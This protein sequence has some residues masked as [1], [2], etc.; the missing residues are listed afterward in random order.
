MSVGEESLFDS[1]LHILVRGASSKEELEKR[2]RVVYEAL[3]AVFQHRAQL[4][5]IEQRESFRRFLPGSL[6][7]GQNALL[8]TARAMATMLPFH[9]QVLFH[10]HGILEGISTTREPIVL[11]WWKL[12][13][14]AR[15]VIG[16]SGWGKSYELRNPWG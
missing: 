6:G 7:A 4:L 3:Y 11:D 13:N 5:L 1:A 10:E 16:S 15:V 14:A 2:S 8:T 9:S 12:A